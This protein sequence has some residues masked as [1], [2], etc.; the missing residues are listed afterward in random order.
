MRLSTF[1]G[2]RR[3]QEHLL[4]QM[5]KTLDVP[6]LF[7][8]SLKLCHMCGYMGLGFWKGVGA[9]ACRKRDSSIF[10]MGPEWS[11]VRTLH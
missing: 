9:K 5:K 7:S 4:Y 6:M 10:N 11:E 3:D 2:L 8:A 1:C